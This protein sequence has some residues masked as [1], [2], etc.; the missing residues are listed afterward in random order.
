MADPITPPETPPAA[1]DVTKL[2]GELAA[3]NKLLEASQAQVAELTEST[4]GNA[5]SVASLERYQTHLT[6]EFETLW[7]SQPTY[8]KEFLTK[9]DFATDPLGGIQMIKNYNSFADKIYEE[10]GGKPP[11]ENPTNT[12]LK[13]P[14][15]ASQEPLTPRESIIAYMK[16]KIG[17]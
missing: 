5:G 10:K 1:P 14:G 15:N 4:A 16:D 9:E 3:T 17:K 8:V 13:Q 11:A 12:K 2:L 6:T 7:E